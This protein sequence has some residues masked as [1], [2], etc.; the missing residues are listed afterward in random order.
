MVDGVF[1]HEPIHMSVPI[2][3]GF[4]FI[5][6]LP[7]EFDGVFVHMIPVIIIDY[8]RNLTGLRIDILGE[9]I[10]LVIGKWIA[11]GKAISSGLRFSK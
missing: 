1:L 4:Q 2:F 6:I 11:V 5:P 9:D 8:F 10:S 3:S 7:I